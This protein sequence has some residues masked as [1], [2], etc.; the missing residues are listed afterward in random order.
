MK[1]GQESYCW[2]DQKL[3]AAN[4][5]QPDSYFL[6]RRIKKKHTPQQEPAR[7]EKI[8]NDTN[9]FIAAANNQLLIADGKGK[10]VIDTIFVAHR[11]TFDL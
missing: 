7:Y 8:I 11:K 10:W 5:K 6:H 1:M 4:D 3:G 2:S 9:H